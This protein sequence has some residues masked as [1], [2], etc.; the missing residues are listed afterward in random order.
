MNS[1]LEICFIHNCPFRQGQLRA[2]QMFI[3]QCDLWVFRLKF[4]T[5]KKKD[6][7]TTGEHKKQKQQFRYYSYIR[8]S[9]N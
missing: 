3:A 8:K 7:Q 1:S 5:E 4:F 6:K 9:Y 2:P